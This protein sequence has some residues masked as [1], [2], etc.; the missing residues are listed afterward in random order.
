MPL[1]FL[2]VSQRLLQGCFSRNYE[3]GCSSCS[4]SAKVPLA[5]VMAPFWTS[6]S[7]LKSGS[8]SK[9]TSSVGFVS[10]LHVAAFPLPSGMFLVDLQDMFWSN[11]LFTVFRRF[12]HM[13]CV[14]RSCF[15]LWERLSVSWQGKHYCSLDVLNHHYAVRGTLCVG[16]IVRETFS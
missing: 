6:R 2:F 14:A 1:W 3:E 12:P 5:A 16:C 11:S 4:L 8:L 10:C 9:S 13:L 7:L 15:N